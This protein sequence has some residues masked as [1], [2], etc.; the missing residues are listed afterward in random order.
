MW[1]SNGEYMIKAASVSR[2]GVPTLDRINSSGDLPRYAEGGLVGDSGG[3]GT[4][5]HLHL[6]DR[7]YPMSASAGVATALTHEARSR[8]MLTT[9][10]KPSWHGG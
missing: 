1:G 2:I 5:V 3:G 6:G 7:S 9:G 4:P 8:H 10:R